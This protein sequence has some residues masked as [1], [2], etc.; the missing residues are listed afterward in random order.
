MKEILLT[1]GYVAIVDDEDYGRVAA[2]K[3]CANVLPRADG[4]VLV[5]AF[6][7]IPN[8]GRVATQYMHRLVMFADSGLQVDHIDGDGLNN[9]KINLRLCS[10]AEN[11]RNQR[12]RS[13]ISSYKG[14]SWHK[15][16]R[17]WLSRIKV[18]RKSIYLGCF[19][20]KEDA[21]RAYDAAAIKYYGEFARTNTYDD[22]S[23]WEAR[24]EQNSERL[25][26]EV[27]DRAKVE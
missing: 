19:E 26:S 24:N 1:K 11:Q 2:H 15:A 18:N 12:V 17:K 21:A 4:S 7:H 5:Y 20:K 3:W 25:C 27:R 6:R 8:C 23:R 14:V 22:C 10:N 16:N 9:T 13:G